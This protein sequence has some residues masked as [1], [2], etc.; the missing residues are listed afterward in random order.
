MSTIAEEVAKLRKES[1]EHVAEAS[2]LEKMAAAYPDLRRHEGRWEK[3]AFCSKSVNA[4]VTDYDMRYN[5]GCCSDSPLELWPYINTDHGKIYSDP[6]MFFI[7]EKSWMGG[8]DP[9]PGWKES[10][11]KEGI[12]ESI[13]DRVKLHFSEEREARI[14]AASAGGEDDG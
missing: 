2:R 7:G 3:V 8:D 5:C 4:L 6:P 10:L 11:R 13:V 12:P 9:R 14:A 1:E